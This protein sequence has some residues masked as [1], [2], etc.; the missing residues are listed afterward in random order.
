MPIFE[1]NNKRVYFAHI[2]KTAGTTVYHAFVQSGW[3]IGNIRHSSNPNSSYQKL[4]TKFGPS[5][6]LENT[7][8]KNTLFPIQ[9]VPYKTWKDF[10]NFDESFAILRNPL[11]R[12]Y[13]ELK[14]RYKIENEDIKQEFD[15][16][17]AKTIRQIKQRPWIIYRGYAG[18]L[19]P[20]H[21]FISANTFLFYL[22]GD[23]LTELSSRYDLDF[24]INKIRKNQSNVKL[25]VELDKYSIMLLRL[26]YYRDYNLIKKHF[27][28]C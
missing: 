22:K 17:T 8:S 28:E 23:W 26:L 14:Y 12:F 21:Y 3:K 11:E 1:K 18:H 16:F 2:P 15:A 9:H 25:E 27:K 4:K 19:I 10:G 13:S 7:N 6:F 5:I 24:D 20:Q